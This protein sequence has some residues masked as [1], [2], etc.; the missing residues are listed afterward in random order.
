MPP[1]GV[2]PFPATGV[3]YYGHTPAVPVPVPV[4]VL[5]AAPP[6]AVLGYPYPY[7]AYPHVHPP[8]AAPAFGGYP[9][10]AAAPYPFGAAP[11]SAAA[12][13]Y[14]APMASTAGSYAGAAVV[15]TGMYPPM[16]ASPLDPRAF[17]A[18]LTTPANDSSS[19]KTTSPTEPRPTQLLPTNSSESE[20]VDGNGSGHAHS[21]HGGAG[22]SNSRT[23]HFNVA[24]SNR[25]ILENRQLIV[26]FL[27]DKTSETQF[28]DLFE[29]HGA[30]E[31]A[32]IIYD[33]KTGHTKGFG[34]ITYVRAAD[35]VKAL[36]TMG[37]YHLH[38]RQ[39]NVALAQTERKRAF[40][41][42]ACPSIDAQM[43]TSGASQSRS[44]VTSAVP[45]GPSSGSTPNSQA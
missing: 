28:R 3:A 26:K 24:L 27:T 37:G 43:P 30:V 38:E 13:P 21:N 42:G 4:P 25:A 40:S 32:R 44:P 16:V 17:A 45:S 11:L 9:P 39:L 31:N 10:Y 6:P 34:F 5:Y 22:A 15:P 2:A 20:S 14:L 19:V 12:W 7:G 18:G 41:N 23:G 35:A 36:R 1:P 8:Y 33:K 29:T